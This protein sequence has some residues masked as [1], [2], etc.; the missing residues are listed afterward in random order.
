MFLIRLI[1]ILPLLFD[2]IILSLFF[3]KTKADFIHVNVSLAKKD[4]F[5]YVNFSEVFWYPVVLASNIWTTFLKNFYTKIY[6]YSNSKQ[7]LIS[8]T[9]LI[10]HQQELV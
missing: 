3:S 7:S 8:F 1:M 10:N 5:F 9:C 6:K 2:F 4:L